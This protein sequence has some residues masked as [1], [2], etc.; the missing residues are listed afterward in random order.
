MKCQQKMLGVQGMPRRDGSRM[1]G[2]IGYGH[3]ILMITIR[4]R[5]S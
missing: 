5:E 2:E 3:V 4:G 1:R